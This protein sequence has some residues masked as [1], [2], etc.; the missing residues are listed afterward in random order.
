MVQKGVGDCGYVK[1]YGRRDQVGCQH[2][3]QDLVFVEAALA[4]DLITASISL[5]VPTSANPFWTLQ[6]RNNVSSRMANRYTG[7]FDA[8]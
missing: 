6:Y 5:H 2:S 7:I 3:L 8:G 4:A 1:G